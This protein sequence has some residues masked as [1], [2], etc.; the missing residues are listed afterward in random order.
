M[1]SGAGHVVLV[2]DERNP[3]FQAGG[4]GYT[5]Y[6]E[7]RNALHEPERLKKCSWQQIARLMR[8]E[9]RLPWLADQLEDKYGI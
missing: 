1:P 9:M 8:E 7:T 5:A 2:H 4:K 3:A 6:E